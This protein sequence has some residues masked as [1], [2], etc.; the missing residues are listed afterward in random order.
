MACPNV[1]LR[2]GR[3]H[4]FRFGVSETTLGGKIQGSLPICD[5]PPTPP[6]LVPLVPLVPPLASSGNSW[7]GDQAGSRYCTASPFWQVESK[8]QCPSP[9]AMGVAQGTLPANQN[10]QHLNRENDKQS[11]SKGDKSCHNYYELTVSIAVYTS[12]GHIPCISVLGVNA[13]GP[14]FPF[15]VKSRRR[16]IVVFVKELRLLASL[17]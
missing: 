17:F 3:V 5:M 7:H 15:Y 10:S 4:G 8:H 14:S 1:S 9:W 13:G 12:C 6:P 11:F 16:E 2:W